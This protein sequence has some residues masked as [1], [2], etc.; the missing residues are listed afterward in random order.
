ME[1]RRAFDILFFFNFPVMSLRTVKAF[2]FST[3]I[4]AALV[5]CY[6]VNVRIAFGFPLIALNLRSGKLNNHTSKRTNRPLKK[7]LRLNKRL[8]LKPG[9]GYS[10]MMPPADLMITFRH[11]DDC[12]H[13]EQSKGSPQ[14]RQDSSRCSEWHD[15][16][17]RLS[18][19]VSLCFKTF[20]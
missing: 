14:R 7:T 18:N 8:M 9:Y 11:E 15:A 12:G 10:P 1:M 20:W 4:R 6:P 16:K 17:V 5:R 19:I 3:T 13:P 2:P